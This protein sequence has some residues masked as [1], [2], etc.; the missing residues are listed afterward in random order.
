M[1]KKKT[2]QPSM[3]KKSPRKIRI[4]DYYTDVLEMKEKPISIAKIEKLGENLFKWA[5]EDEDAFKVRSF[6]TKQ[7]IGGDDIKRWRGRSPKFDKAYKMA[8]E[9]IGDRREIGGLKRT[10]DSSIVVQSM[11]HYDPDWR[12]LAQWRSNLRA[13]EKEQAAT[14]FT[15]NMK[16]FSDEAEKKNDGPTKGS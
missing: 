7:S 11:P 6:F 14:T 3:K 10:F 13:Q 1:V 2:L 4:Y 8:L 5:L 9:L 15:V 16:S 12:E